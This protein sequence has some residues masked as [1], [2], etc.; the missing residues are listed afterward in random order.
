MECFCFE[1]LTTVTDSRSA[2]ISLLGCDIIVLSLHHGIDLLVFFC[3][4]IHERL[5]Y[6]VFAC[7]IIIS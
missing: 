2:T 1:R 3:A 7:D 6:F 4:C 5:M